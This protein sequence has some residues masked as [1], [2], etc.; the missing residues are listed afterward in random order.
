[1]KTIEN[2]ID[3]PVFEYNFPHD[4]QKILF[5]DIETT[6]LSPKASSLYL[7]GAMYFDTSSE[8]WKLIQWFADDYKS[9]A[10]IINSFLKLLEDFDY[11]YHF[12]GR[13]FDIPYLLSK[14]KKYK[15]TPGSH[16]ANIFNDTSC[17]Y[18]IDI[19]AL[20]RPLKKLLSIEKASQTDLERWLSIKRTDEYNGGELITVYSKY[21]QNKIISPECAPELENLLLLHNHDDIEQ[22][23]NVCSIL[24][25]REIFSE[26]NDITVFDIKE[27][28]NSEVTNIIEIYF[29]QNINIPKP[30][31]IKNALPP[32][33]SDVLTSPDKISEPSVTLSL[34]NDIGIL[35]C[36][37][38]RGILKNFYPNYKD[39]Y[40]FPEEDTVIHKSLISS[41]I[42]K[43]SKKATAST[44]YTKKEGFFIPSGTT[45]SG[46][47][48][49]TQF[50]LT[51]HDKI[52]FYMLPNEIINPDNP[53]WN[54][55]VIMQL[56]TF[57]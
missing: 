32:S 47:E 50:Y 17:I 6:G 48:N 43:L 3:A 12:N 4:K 28:E 38:F 15:I 46:D 36:Q 55:Y 9:E 1:M 20:I 56:S 30:I 54:N 39:Y 41:E 8:K 22:M 16:C 49:I 26:N 42:K 52:C 24:T 51:Y 5:F 29:K 57:L 31:T 13:T 45:R 33:K 53:F 23:L 18:S 19:L 25:Y 10:H 14:C 2:N 11:L 40:Y 34:K 7:I 35:S 27:S 44:C 21:M 37:V